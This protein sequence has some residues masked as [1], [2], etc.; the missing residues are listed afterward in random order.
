VA[1]VCVYIQPL[2]DFAISENISPQHAL[3]MYPMSQPAR[4]FQQPNAF[5][6]PPQQPQLVSPMNEMSPMM[7][8]AAMPGLTNSPQPHYPSPMSSQT[9]QTGQTGPNTTPLLANRQPPSSAPAK[10]NQTNKRRRGSAVANMSMKEEDEESVPSQP[11]KPPKQSP[12]IGMAG[13]GGGPGGPPG[14]R[15]R[16]DP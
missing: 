3:E 14:K 4:V 2:I 9:S 16:G 1:E 11:Q 15:L 8:H 7:A 5:Q 6:Y 12:R 13:R 10:A